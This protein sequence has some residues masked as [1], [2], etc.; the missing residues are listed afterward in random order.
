MSEESHSQSCHKGNCS[1]Q[2][3]QIIQSSFERDSNHS[4]CESPNN[5]ENGMSFNCLSICSS[6]VGTVVSQKLIPTIIFNNSSPHYKSSLTKND[7][8]VRM[9]KPPKASVLF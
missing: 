5:C 9:F 3:I 4:N 6:S 8:V 1:D 7:F 2:K